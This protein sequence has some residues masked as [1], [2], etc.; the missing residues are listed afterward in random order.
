MYPGPIRTLI[1]AFGKL[2]GVGRRTAERFVFSLLSQ[3]KKDVGELSQAL[4]GLMQGIRSCEVCWNFT[5]TSPCQRCRD[6]SR[7]SDLLCVVANP[8]DI[9]TIERTGLYNGHFHVLRGTI[10]T[11]VDQGEEKLKIQELFARLSQGTW[12]E[13][14]L[15]FNPDFAGETTMLFLE[16]ELHRGYPNLRITRLARGI[17]IGGDLAY[18]DDLTLKSAL[19]NR[20]VLGSKETV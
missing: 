8:S 2:P 17:P 10:E 3:G 19:T 13:I 4:L 16:Q 20:T 12:R 15:A 9:E 7:T 11:D 6:Q 18:A 5:E 14:L 1:T